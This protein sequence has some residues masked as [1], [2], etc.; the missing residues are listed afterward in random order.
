MKIT[1]DYWFS[2]MAALVGIVVGEDEITGE[3][4]AYIGV[5]SGI[6]QEVDAK[7]VAQRGAKLPLAILDEIRA[8]LAPPGEKTTTKAEILDALKAQHEAIDRLFAQLIERDA[9]F[10][11]SKSGQPWEAAR[12]GNAVTQKLGV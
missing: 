2:G 12:K 9:D 1:Y 6:D 11:P 10:R 5:A 8:L 4:K 7:I 3:C